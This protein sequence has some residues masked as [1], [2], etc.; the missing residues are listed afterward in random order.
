MLYN[1]LLKKETRPVHI[2]CPKD[3]MSEKAIIENLDNISKNLNYKF[4]KI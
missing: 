2:D 1:I 3:I 4:Q